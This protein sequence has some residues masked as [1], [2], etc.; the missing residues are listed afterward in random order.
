ML[1][2]NGYSVPSHCCCIMLVSSFLSAKRVHV[3]DYIVL[4]SHSYMLVE[5][6]TCWG[7]KPH[8]VLSF[9]FASQI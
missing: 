3:Y 8:T 2:S 4:W 7:T 5:S 9:A 6:K 1:V